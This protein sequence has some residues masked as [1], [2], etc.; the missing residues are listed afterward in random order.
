MSLFVVF[1][2]SSNSKAP[3]GYAIV[4]FDTQTDLETNI[5]NDQT[6]KIGSFAKEPSVVCPKTPDLKMKISG[7]YQAEEGVTNRVGIEENDADEQR[8]EDLEIQITLGTALRMTDKQRSQIDNEPQHPDDTQLQ[9][10]M[11][12]VR[13][14]A[15]QIPLVLVGEL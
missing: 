5:I 9:I 14:G 6:V 1:G 15:H 11:N 3:E 13:D 4:H 7:W 12:Q 2:C 8:H 10:D